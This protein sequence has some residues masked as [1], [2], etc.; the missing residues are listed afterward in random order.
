[1]RG[2]HEAVAARELLEPDATVVVR[3][4]LALESIELLDSTPGNNSVPSSST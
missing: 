2:G 4:K 1:V 3:R